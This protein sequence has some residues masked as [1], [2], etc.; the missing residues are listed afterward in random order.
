MNQNTTATAS[1][2]DLSPP[3]SEVPSPVLLVEDNI[4]NQKATLL[5][6]EK[7]GLQA[8]VVCNGMEAI[9]AVSHRKFSLILM[10]CYMPMMD[11]FEAT[12]AIRE[13]ET[14]RGTYTPIIAVTALAMSGDRERCIS[15]GMD[16]YISKPIDFNIFQAKLNYWLNTN[17][18]VLQEQAPK[19]TLRSRSHLVLVEES[20]IDMAELSQIYTQEEIEDL[21]R[22]FHRCAINSLWRIETQVRERNAIFVSKLAHE[23]RAACLCIRHKQLSQLCLYLE[24]AAGQEDW[25]EAY[26]TTRNMHV[27]LNEFEAYLKASS[28]KDKSGRKK[29]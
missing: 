11:G 6:L 15:A 2:S 17:I 21:L 5:L 18:N 28:A 19:R 14:D 20:P 8:V 1:S 29:G 12:V 9:D 23:L 27:A 16:D 4:I 10:D 25:L 22:V 13:I 3:I 7:I 26:V 24:M